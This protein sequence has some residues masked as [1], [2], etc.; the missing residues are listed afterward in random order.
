MR[1]TMNSGLLLCGLAIAPAVHAQTVSAPQTGNTVAGQGAGTTPN[2]SRAAAGGDD[3]DTLQPIGAHFGSFTLYPKLE[4]AL[5]YNDNIYS[6]ANKTGDGIARISPS[7]DLRGDFGT[8]TTGL[9]ASLDRYQYFTNVTENRTDWSIGGN[10]QAEVSRDVF[11]Y[12]AGGYS[13]AHEDRG[14]PNAVYTDR[15]PTKYR[16]S[17]AGLGFSSDLTRFSYGVDASYRYYKY[18][19]NRQLGGALVNNQDRNRAQ[20]RVAGRLGYEFS[21]GYRLLARGS[22]DVVDYKS[23]FDDGGFNRDSHGVR[24]TIGI[25]FELTHLLTG[26]VFAGYLSQTYDDPRFPT[27]NAPVFGSKLTWQPTALTKVK[28][29]IDRAV[30]ETIVANFRSFLATSV[31]IGVDHELLRTVTLNGSF[32]YE[33]DDYKG[34][35]ALPGNRTDGYYSIS[36]GGK[37]LLNRNIYAG[38]VYDWNKRDS[39]VIAPGLNYDRNRVTA[40]LGLQF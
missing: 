27:L 38:L 2:K 34:S 6:L 15:T 20:Y 7:L 13:Q 33:S 8:I 24:G 29:D 31:A 39:N 32:R 9:R 4:T 23:P 10:A 36:A 40:T 1:R 26:E 22:Y 21:P 11:I 12:A 25:E 30:Q 19:D 37:Y 14:D 5:T 28:L 16:L 35:R 18:D 3:A 17:E